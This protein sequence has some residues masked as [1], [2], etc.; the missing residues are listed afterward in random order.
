MAREISGNQCL[1]VT[2]LKEDESVDE[3]STRRMIEFL[4]EN[5]VHGILVHGSTGEGFL[6]D[7]GERKAYADLVVN[8]VKGRVPVGFCV[9]SSSTA[10]SV[11]LSK[12]AKKAGCDYLFTTAPYR[13]PHK[14]N[15]IFEHFKA[16]NDATDLPVSIYDGGAGIE[17]GLDLF[18]KISEELEHVKYCKI[19]LEKPEKIAQIKDRTKG[20]ITPWA[21][22][23]RLTYLMLCYGAYGMTSA[24]SCVIPREN[25]DM[26]DFAKA[27]K[28]DQARHIFLSKV[29]PLN[30]MGFFS[31][32]DFIAA[33]KLALYWMGIIK[34]PTVRKPLIQLDSV[35]QRELRGALTFIGKL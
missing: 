6:F 28:F 29:C 10:V 21:G 9:E 3:P 33:Y 34:T 23:D 15:G 1:I 12:Y 24:A 20:R 4:I 5:G 11:D 7:T 19:F 26:F 25:S 31:V 17:L 2:P 32:L 35:M 30:A 16:I 27:G 13:H 22:H 18:E 14:G 8:A